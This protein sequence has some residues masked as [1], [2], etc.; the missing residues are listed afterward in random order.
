MAILRFAMPAFAGVLTLSAAPSLS[1]NANLVQAAFV[2][3]GPGGIPVARV[4]TQADQC[5]AISV[6]GH[7]LTMQLRAAPSTEPLRPTASAAELSK[8]SAF[9]V[10]VCEMALPEG[11]KTAVL[12]GRALPLPSSHIDRIVVIGDT[13]CRLKAKDDAWQACNDPRQYPFARIAARAAAWKPDLVVH[14]GDYLY[15]ENPCPDGNVGCAGSPWGYGWDAWNADFFQP[16]S[17]LL[18]TAPW[19][20]ARGNHENCARAGQGWWRLLDPR[21]LLA[22]RDCN[23]AEN[24]SQGDYSP[25]YAV[26][27]GK[28]AQVVVMDLSHAGTDKIAP[29]D[30]RIAQYSQTARMLGVMAKGKAFTFAVDHYPF[31]GVTAQAK[32]GG[33]IKLGAGNKALNPIFAQQDR[34]IMPKGVDVLLAGH[35]H[36]WEQADFGGAEPSQFVAGF[37]G[38]QE[39]TVP[40]PHTLPANVV[41]APATP[42]RQFDAVVASFGFMTLQRTGQRAWRARVFDDEGNELRKCRIDRRRSSCRAAR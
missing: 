21:Q 6:D 20:L 35:I 30:P 33:K 11:T 14:V 42:I 13:G 22:G 3:L 29:S 37:S 16:G 31:L 7:K 4:I 26:P 8:P 1:D 24:D 18:A 25:P 38:T 10:R 39:D 36:V 34:R 12:G 19:A 2:A 28:G 40:L 17:P 27:L 5:P 32:P 23:D 41:P 9:P 15:R